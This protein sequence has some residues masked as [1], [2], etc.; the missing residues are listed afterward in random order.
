M[1]PA[2]RSDDTRGTW[3]CRLEDSDFEDYDLTSQ[4]IRGADAEDAATQ[5]A[6]ALCHDDCESYEMFENGAKVFIRGRDGVEHTFTV[7]LDWS[8]V[9]LAYEEPAAPS[10]EVREDAN[11]EN[12]HPR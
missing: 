9:F 1:Q 11:Q 2:P 10:D 5:F 6:E 3:A 12:T 4:K 8:P 7:R